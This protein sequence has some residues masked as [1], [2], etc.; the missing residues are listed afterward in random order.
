[1]A[2]EWRGRGSSDR[3]PIAV[4]QRGEAD[5]KATTSKALRRPRARTG[6]TFV[7]AASV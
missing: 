7:V 4:T 6:M 1:M 3:A 2:E 5:V